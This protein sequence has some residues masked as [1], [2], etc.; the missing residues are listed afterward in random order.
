MTP[1]RWPR[2]VT[3][4][5]KPTKPLTREE[6]QQILDENLARVLAKLTPEQRARARKLLL[7]KLEPKKIRGRPSTTLTFYAELRRIGFSHGKAVKAA[8]RQA[9]RS[10]QYVERLLRKNP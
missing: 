9:K 6:W 10:E 1:K 8:A 4:F 3:I 5:D 7:K 2:P